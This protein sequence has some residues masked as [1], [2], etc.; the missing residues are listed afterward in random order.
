MASAI[1]TLMVIVHV[2]AGAA[3]YFALPVPGAA[4]AMAGIA[5]SLWAQVQRGFGIAVRAAPHGSERLQGRILTTRL[6]V[7][8][9]AR[10]S[11]GRIFV[12]RGL[13]DEFARR[14]RREL[15][16]PA[17]PEKSARQ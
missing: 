2:A 7:L 4:L 9:G 8:A 5:I 13:D 14:L 16:W 11:D 10:A 12:G 17:P 15:R 6:I 3:V 1:V